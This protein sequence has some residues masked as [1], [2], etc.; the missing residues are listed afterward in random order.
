M[1]NFYTNFKLK[2][3]D[4]HAVARTMTPEWRSAFISPVQGDYGVVYWLF[5]KGRLIDTYNSASNYF[6]P[7]EG[8]DRGEDISPLMI[9]GASRN[10]RVRGQPIEATREPYAAGFAFRSVIRAR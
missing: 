6:N 1:G 8:A 7:A 2:T 3:T 5:D 9:S 4:A 10:D